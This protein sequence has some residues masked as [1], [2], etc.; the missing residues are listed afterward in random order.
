MKPKNPNLANPP[1]PVSAY[2]IAGSLPVWE[3]VPQRYQQELVMSLA[4]LL[5]HRPELH[6]L[7][8]METQGARHEPER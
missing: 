5:L 3:Q 7:L 2:V 6:P 4:A 8:Q 1:Q